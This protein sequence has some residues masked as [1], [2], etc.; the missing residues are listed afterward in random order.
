MLAG[1]SFVTHAGAQEVRSYVIDLNNRTAT[2]LVGP[3]GGDLRATAIN[4]DGQVV[5][6]FDTP[7]G[8]RHALTT[9]PNRLGVNALG[10]LPGASSSEAYAINDAG[11]VVGV[12]YTEGDH[13]FH[14]FIT[15][16][17]GVGMRDLGT[18]TFGRDNSWAHGI[19]DEG[20][21]VGWS[22]TS[23]GARHAFITRPRWREHGGPEFAGLSAARDYS[24]RG[25]WDQ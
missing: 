14:A 13:R 20:Q 9:G 16:P 22:D 8:N 5:G 21:V 3:T 23:G 24:N 17:D 25:G 19:N 10:T 18:L 6:Y 1:L 15:G 11:Q 12:S 7:G 4:D 2:E